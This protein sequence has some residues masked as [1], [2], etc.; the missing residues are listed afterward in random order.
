MSL[1]VFLVA[2]LLGL[3]VSQVLLAP[4]LHLITSIQRH[5]GESGP[6]RSPPA[7]AGP[8]RASPAAPWGSSGSWPC[9][10]FK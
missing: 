4:V 2:L 8:G 6:P 10:G 5:L 1:V 7:K 3:V 9:F